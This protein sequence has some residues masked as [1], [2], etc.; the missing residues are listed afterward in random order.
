MRSAGQKL[1]LVHLF[2]ALLSVLG[3]GTDQYLSVA[4][5]NLRTPD[6]KRHAIHMP[7]AI[8]DL[9]PRYATVYSL[10]A[11]VALPE[12]LRGRP[13]TLTWPGSGAFATLFVDGE[14]ILPLSRAPFDRYLPSQPLVFRIP[15]GKTGGALLHLELQVQHVEMMT[16]MRMPYAMR[17]GAAEYGDWQTRAGIYITRAVMTGVAAI[18]SLLGLSAGVSFL[19]DRRRKAD[20]WFALLAFA[21][22]VWHVYDL[23][24]LQH[25][26]AA[27]RTPIFTTPLL[28]ISSIGFTQ[29]YYRLKPPRLTQLGVIALSVT[30]AVVCWA[31]FSTISPGLGALQF[32]VVLVYQ[33]VTLGRMARRR[34]RRFDALCM[35]GVW[36]LLVASAFMQNSGADVRY[37]DAPPIAALIFVVTLAI[38]LLRQ[39][40]LELRALNVSLQDRV[41]LLEERNREV[42]RLNDELRLQIH[43][44]SARLVDALG[45]IGQ[46]SGAKQKALPVGAVIGDRYKVVRSLGQGGMGAVYEVER[47]TD[48]RRFALKT[49]LQADSGAWLARLA[50][51]AQA[52]TAIVHP[53]VVGIVDI[54]IDA[55]GMPFIVMELV[56]GEPLSAQQQRFGDATFARDVVRQVATGL[57]ALHQAGIVHRDLKPANV[58]LQRQPGGVFCAKIVDFGIARVVSQ[59]RQGHAV[60]AGG[61]LDT[62][63]FRAFVRGATDETPAADGALTRTG[64]L[65]GTP[66][67]MAPELAHGVKDASPSC[68]LWSLGVLAYQIGCGKLPFAE[69]PVNSTGEG[70]WQPPPIDMQRLTEPLRRVVER[71]LDVDPLRRPTAAE[72]ATALA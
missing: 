7:C 60:A 63:G 34:E 10:D 14:G 55:S 38:L 35:M 58:L 19:L 1:V 44:R 52:A 25:F 2:V 16:V 6:G 28:C 48:G 22:A 21:L 3:C 47:T 68:D 24:L 12:S 36:T 8:H 57:A 53:N 9:L 59:S 4:D 11:D 33:L 5:W 65:L 64:W 42:S 30:R 26:A 41:V 15:A 31:P 51:E 67:Y 45:R 39:H 23:V 56:D 27:W 29:A 69:P 46:L 13:L 62:G 61:V 40:A 37:V 66:L 43:D 17:L 70:A 18:F 54:D 71:C 32:A 72:A 50:R 20:G 49:L